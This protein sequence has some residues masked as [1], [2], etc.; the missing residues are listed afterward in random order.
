MATTLEA[1]AGDTRTLKCTFVDE[2]DSPRD[3]DDVTF[4]VYFERTLIDTYTDVTHTGTGV[5]EYDYTFPS[6][7]A[8]L[9]IEFKGYYSG[10]PQVARRFVDVIWTNDE[11][12]SFD[13]GGTTDGTT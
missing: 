2:T 3:L 8:Q 12:I 10:Y 7:Y 4:S 5:Y 13:S 6:E 9:V 1:L 11:S